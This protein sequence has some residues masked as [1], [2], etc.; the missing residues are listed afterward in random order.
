MSQPES[1]D[2]EAAIE[3]AARVA[4]FN[5]WLA[6][7]AEEQASWA[8]HASVTKEDVLNA[9][10]AADPVREITEANSAPAK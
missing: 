7:A 6:C 9:L 1:W 3:M 8:D 10:G 2:R 4:K 5:V